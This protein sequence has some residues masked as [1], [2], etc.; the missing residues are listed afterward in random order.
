MNHKGKKNYTQEEL[1]QGTI[2]PWADDDVHTSEEELDQILKIQERLI[3]E[4]GIEDR[5]P[6]HVKRRRKGQGR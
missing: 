1:N 6:E 4:G 2:N 3:N 5:R